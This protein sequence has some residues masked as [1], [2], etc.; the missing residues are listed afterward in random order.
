LEIDYA[1]FY[2]WP[3]NGTFIDLVSKTQEYFNQNVI[4]NSD[5]DKKM[6]ALMKGMNSLDFI[7]LKA[8]NFNEFYNQ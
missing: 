3:K 2:K 8:S 1:Q 5:V 6:D 7:E 4:Q